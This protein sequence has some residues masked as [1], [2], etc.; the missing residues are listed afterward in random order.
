MMIIIVICGITLGDNSKIWGV[1]K[2]HEMGGLVKET[3]SFNW[4]ELGQGY[5]RARL[6]FLLL[7]VPKG[8]V[9]KAKKLIKKK[10]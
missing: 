4:V 10:K 5:F 8:K 9:Q 7:L 2:S 1:V 3:P 6:S